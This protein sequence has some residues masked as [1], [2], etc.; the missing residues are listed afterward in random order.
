MFRRSLLR[1]RATVSSIPAFRSRTPCLP[2]LFSTTIGGDRETKGLVPDVQLEY[3]G[4]DA[5]KLTITRSENPK[6]P[7]PKEQLVFGRNF[8]DHM[9]TAEWTASG[10]WAA[11]AI[12][13]YQ[14]ICLDPSTCVFHYGIECFEGQKAYC[15]ADGSIRLF[16]CD[17]NMARL[18]GSAARLALPTFDAEQLQDLLKA[19]VR[20]DQRL[21]PKERGYSLY[22]RTCM[23]G[24]QPTLG[25]GPSA[26]ALLFAIASPVGP[27]YS[28]G[29]KA[30]DLEATSESI[31]AW[32]G[33]VG[34][35]KLGA[36]YGPCI[37]PQLMASKR[38]FH[39]NLWLF[40]EEQRVTEV[41]AMNFF[42]IFRN[43]RGDRELVTPPLDG[44]ILNGITRDSVL[45]LARER[46]VPEGWTVSERYCTMEEL[47]TASGEG[48]LEEAFGVGT[49]A[50][51]SPIRS[52]GWN[53]RTVDCGLKPGQE[54]GETA[55]RLKNWI[56]E[57]QYGE[58]PHVWSTPV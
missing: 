58:V 57:I 38:G 34:D 49:A 32:P 53:G 6:E 50:V 33:G 51:V 22:I 9:L 11:P 5:S 40:G 18:N 46:L 47:A 24:T 2:R 16:R 55:V 8:T 10:G 48:R 44:T 39:Q 4:L 14:K 25:I 3:P 17:M 12:V 13:P 42:A 31:R 37:L 20:L 41:G 52:I 23:I 56:E 36:N 35:K 30:V 45:A 19:L 28:T 7:L 15:A 21:I 1:V 54:A 43:P 26:S 29:F 27:Y